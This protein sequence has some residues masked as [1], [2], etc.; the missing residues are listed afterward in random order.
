M[1]KELPDLAKSEWSL[2]E[3]LWTREQATASALQADL[4]STQ[5]WAYSTVKT[6]L[7]RL[8]EKGYVKSRR[9][10][11]VYEYSPKIRRGAVV[12]RS[13]DDLAERVLSGSISPLIHRLVES[14]RLNNDEIRELRQMLD[15]YPLSPDKERQT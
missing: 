9:I 10:G 2:M 3:A 15:S 8:V 13:I 1:N 7:D 11:N 12:A 14:R 4:R 5:D 6:M